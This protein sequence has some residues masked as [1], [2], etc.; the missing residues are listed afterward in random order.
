M[1]KHTHTDKPALIKRRMGTVTATSIVVANMIGAGIFTTSGLMASHL[2]SSGWIYFCWIL[3]GLVA[4]SGALC[5]T[6]L[7]T[8]M[9]EEG[10]EYVYMKKLFLN[11]H[12]NL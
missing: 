12:L 4:L 11:L 3:G 10:G 8:R 9:P 1:T 2:P 5:Y 7:A 6:E